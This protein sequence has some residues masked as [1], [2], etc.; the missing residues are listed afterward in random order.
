MKRVTAIATAVF[1]A[2]LVALTFST[3][4]AQ[5][6]NSHE[7]TY[8]TFSGPVELPGMT[9]PAGTYTFRLADSPM[10]NVVQVLS[11]DEKD[12]KGQFL[13]VQHTRPEVTGDTVVTFKET[14]ENTT[15]AVQYWYYPGEKIGKEFVYPREQ[16][17]KIAARTHSTVL[18]TEGEVTP[19]SQVSSVDENGKVT[20]WQREQSAPAGSGSAEAAQAA[21]AQSPSA[22]AQPSAAAGSLA[23]NRGAQT[24]SDDTRRDT[25]VNSD[26]S[27]Q[28]VATSGQ[29]SASQQVAANELPKT[30]SP[31]P[32]SGLLG[33]LSAASGLGLRAFRR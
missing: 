13:F 18:S 4:K 2:L 24:Q 6:L 5:D 22:P 17:T 9:L 1:M 14:A 23:G 7:K 21:P 11:Q 25:S 30:A 15:P 33:L 32:L 8:L 3:V 20:V 26:A 10:R 28:P 31:L 27:N 19:D 29:S 16:A 12:I